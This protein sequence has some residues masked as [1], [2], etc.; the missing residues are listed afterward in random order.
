[1][2]VPICRL[3][4]S[5]NKNSFPNL[6]DYKRCQSFNFWTVSFRLTVYSQTAVREKRFGLLPVKQ[7]EVGKKKK[8]GSPIWSRNRSKKPEAKPMICCLIILS[9]FLNASFRQS[10]SQLSPGLLFHCLWPHVPWRTGSKLMTQQCGFEQLNWQKTTT[11]FKQRES[12]P[13]DSGLGAKTR[14][15]L[16]LSGIASQRSSLILPSC[17]IIW[18]SFSVWFFSSFLIVTFPEHN[19]YILTVNSP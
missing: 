18:K 11:L 13:A 2:V 8:K 14:R 7:K 3:F 5:S 1:M 19:Y 10:N 17:T 6:S 16:A 9:Y 4:L 12:L 15:K